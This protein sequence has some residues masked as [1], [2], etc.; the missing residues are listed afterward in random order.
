MQNLKDGALQNLVAAYSSH[1]FIIDY[2]EATSLFKRAREANE[3]VESFFENL[4][5]VTRYQSSIS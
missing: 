5:R 2:D 3:V 1:G 4:G